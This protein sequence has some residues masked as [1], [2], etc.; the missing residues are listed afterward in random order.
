MTIHILIT[1]NDLL[2][3]DSLGL[4]PGGTSQEDGTRHYGTPMLPQG[5]HGRPGMGMSMNIMTEDHDNND[6]FFFLCRPRPRSGP[7]AT[8]QWW[9]M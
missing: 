3:F 9:T 2:L 8:A 4:P 5:Y 6:F 7:G 1:G